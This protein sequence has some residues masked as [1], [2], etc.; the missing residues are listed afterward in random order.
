MAAKR[1]SSAAAR[2]A[3]H[4]FATLERATTLDEAWRIVLSAPRAPA[5]GTERFTRLAHFL[6]HLEPAPASSHDELRAYLA[7]VRRFLKSSSMAQPTA[8]RAIA[9]LMDAERALAATKR[10]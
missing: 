2:A 4:Y 1:Q 5:L 6:K 9:V 7:L 3:E 8:L 10:G